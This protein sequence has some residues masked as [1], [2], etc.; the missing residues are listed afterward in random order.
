MY[1]KE[2]DVTLRLS[3]EACHILSNQLYASMLLSSSNSATRMSYIPTEI[4]N[5]TSKKVVLSSVEN[6]TIEKRQ[7]GYRSMPRISR[8]R[9]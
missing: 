6:R 8:I 5:S 1:A 4:C 2:D 3:C 9:T 7:I